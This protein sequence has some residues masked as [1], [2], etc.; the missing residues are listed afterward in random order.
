MG[1]I[2]RAFT[3]PGTGG[4]EAAEQIAAG[5]AAKAAQARAAP[6]AAPPAAPTL[7]GAP[8]PPPAFA[9]GTSPGAKQRAQLTATSMLG[10][11][12]TTGQTAKKTLLG[13]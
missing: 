8:P 5:E 1:F 2:E 3:P 7:P 13:Q 9:P 11:A 4:R 6:V 10:A 12:A